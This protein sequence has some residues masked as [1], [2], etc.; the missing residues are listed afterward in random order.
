M[1]TG[2]GFY[3]KIDIP[4][5]LV[6]ICCHGILVHLDYVSDK[7]YLL[8]LSSFIFYGTVYNKEP[9]KLFDMSR[10]LSPFLFSRYCHDC[11]ESNVK[12]YSL[13]ITTRA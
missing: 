7:C 9:L 2:Y 3:F 1:K 6:V 8:L 11:A 13:E 5:L 4:S 10:A 12:Q